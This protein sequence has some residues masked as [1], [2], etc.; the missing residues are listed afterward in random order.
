[1]ILSKKLLIIEISKLSM[2]NWIRNT[3]S[4]FSYA[5]LF[6]G[7]TFFDKNAGTEHSV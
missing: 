3:V 6:Q 5:P 7:P 1:M 4:H 2:T